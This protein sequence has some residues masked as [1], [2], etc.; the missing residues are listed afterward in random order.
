MDVQE[1]DVTIRKWQQAAALA[2]YPFTSSVVGEPCSF[3]PK[4]IDFGK[5]PRRKKEK[6]PPAKLEDFIWSYVSGT[7]DFAEN[8]PVVPGF[9]PLGLRLT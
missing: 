9:G 3:L 1:D 5:R 2:D 7:R 4:R 8:Q 6:K